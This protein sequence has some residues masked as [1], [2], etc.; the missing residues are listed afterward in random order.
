MVGWRFPA[1]IEQGQTL[2]GVLCI[3]LT[4]FVMVSVM[5]LLLMAASR[6]VAVFGGLVPVREEKQDV[7]IRVE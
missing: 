2:K 5:T 7:K 6:W 3:A 4:V 1:L